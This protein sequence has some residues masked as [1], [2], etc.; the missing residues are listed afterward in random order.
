MVELEEA[1]RRAEAASQAKS[2]F[3]AA[4]SHEIR[5][6]MNGI[7]GMAGLL[8]ATPQTPEQQTYVHAIDRSA[9]ALLA[10]VDDILDLS[11]VEAGKPVIEEAPFALETCL[12]EAVELLSPLAHRKALSL[13]WA[14]DFRL[15]RPVVGDAARV[16][17][18][19]LNLVSNSI[20]FTHVG[21]VTV[22]AALGDDAS[23]VTGK[24]VRVRLQ[25]QDTGVGLTT[26][27]IETLFEDFEQAASAVTHGNGGTGLGLAISRRLAR[28]MGGDI[29]VVSAPERGA[30]FTVGLPLRWARTDEIAPV[31]GDTAWARPEGRLPGAGKRVLLV[32]DNEINAL[33]A[34]RMLEKAGCDVVGVSDGHAAVACVTRARSEQAPP[35]DLILMD[36]LLPGLDGFEVTRAIGDLY[37]SADGAPGRRPPIVALTAN[38]FAEDRRRCL[39][40]GMDDYLS[41]PFDKADLDAVLMR[42]FEFA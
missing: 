35:F 27:E 15:R 26:A 7:L 22:N 38:A 32:E 30:I 37:S 41:K 10:L 42:W 29:T 34:R 5:T 18:I 6:P 14:V 21:R 33:L 28:A 19:V 31:A 24:E 11:K 3:L 13:T 9:R 1:R 16:R 40:A 23:P 2:R 36:I 17:R 8:L 20:K 39:D 25:V 4:V 12:R